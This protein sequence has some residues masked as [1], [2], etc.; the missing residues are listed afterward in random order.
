MVRPGIL[1]AINKEPAMVIAGVIAGVSMFMPY[2][3]VPI[4]RSL[5]LPTYQWDANPETHPVRAAA[6]S[7]RVRW[8][9][10]RVG[11]ARRARAMAG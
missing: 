6:G 1:A 9:R 10:R 4:R 3:V 7:R 8:R 11:A 5:G 2:V